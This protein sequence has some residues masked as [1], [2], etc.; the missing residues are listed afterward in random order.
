MSYVFESSDARK[1]RLREQAKEFRKHGI[2]A[3]KWGGD[4]SYSWA[5][6]VDGRQFVNGLSRDQVDY[7]KRRALELA[8]GGSK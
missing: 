7:Y 1:A 3:K 4:D 6:F 2:T 8:K 5:V